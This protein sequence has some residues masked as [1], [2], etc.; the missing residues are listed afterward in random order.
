[1]SGHPFVDP[2]SG[3]EVFLHMGPEDF[4]VQ[5]GACPYRA[6]VHP[7]LD[8]FYCSHCQ[9]CGRISGAW[10]MNLLRAAGAAGGDQE[11]TP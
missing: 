7:H 8:A 9:W 4:G 5:H 2:S 10:F 3:L 11:D 1:M 6:E